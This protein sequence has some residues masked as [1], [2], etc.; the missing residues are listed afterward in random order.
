MPL[1]SNVFIVVNRDSWF[2]FSKSEGEI[3]KREANKRDKEG[4]KRTKG[5]EQ[6]KRI[7]NN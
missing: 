7:G 5:K 4:T 3:W 1:Y 2:Y 6:E